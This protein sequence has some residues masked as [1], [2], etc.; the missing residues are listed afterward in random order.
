MHIYSYLLISLQFYQKFYYYL[1]YI[2]IS[3]KWLLY[4]ISYCIFI[5]VLKYKNFK[6]TAMYQSCIISYM[7]TFQLSGYWVRVVAAYLS[8][9][10][11]IISVSNLLQVY[12]TWTIMCN[13]C[14]FQLSG[15][16]LTAVVVYLS[17]SAST[18]RISNL[19]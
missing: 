12:Q 18:I 2:Y 9:F 11:N 19:L 17:K 8:K 14:I 10:E 15:Y 7:F 3:S 16:C 5:Q 4:D 1:Q 6:S 13:L